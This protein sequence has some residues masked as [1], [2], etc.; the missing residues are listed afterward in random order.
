MIGLAALLVTLQEVLAFAAQV[1][2]GDVPTLFGAFA[3]SASLQLVGGIGAIVGLVLSALIGAMLT[4]MIVVVVS[5]DVLGYRVG[6]GEVWRRVRPR[7]PALLAAAL[8]AGVVPYI[9]LIFLVLPGALLWGGWALT[10]PALVIE[11]LG[12]LQAVRRAWRLG[13]PDF[14]RVWGIRS[15][16]VL[17]S[18]VMQGLVVIPFA[19]LGALLAAIVGAD[20]SD[21][22]PL[23][24]LACVVLGSILGG[25]LTQPFLAGV[26]ALLYIDRRMRAEGLDIVMQQQARAARRLGGWAG[27]G[28]IMAVGGSVAGRSA[29]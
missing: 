7:V 22:L 15:L 6:A 18:F 3:G 16:S 19:A 13:F 11:G 10:T 23:V 21:P 2:T 27:G 12:P 5:D 9:G 20:P 24:A 17:L 8:I 14:W 25:I 26:L 29:P 1:G 28:P 4:G